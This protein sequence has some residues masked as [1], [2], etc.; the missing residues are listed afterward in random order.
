MATKTT[1]NRFPVNIVDSFG[2]TDGFSL[3]SSVTVVAGF[4]CRSFSLERS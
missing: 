4:I 3:A 1:A 2:S